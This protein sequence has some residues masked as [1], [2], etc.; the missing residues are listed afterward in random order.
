M[1]LFYCAFSMPKIIVKNQQSIIFSEVEAHYRITKHI[2]CLVGP[3]NINKIKAILM[4]FC[5]KPC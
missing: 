4:A 2:G 1:I 3:I 5:Q